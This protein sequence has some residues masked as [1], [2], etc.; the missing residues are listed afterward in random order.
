MVSDE[1]LVASK[2]G[3]ARGSLSHSIIS[4]LIPSYRWVVWSGGVLRHTA[5]AYYG[6]EVV[7]GEGRMEDRMLGF[8][9]LNPTY[10]L[11]GKN[12][13]GNRISIAV[14]IRALDPLRLAVRSVDLLRMRVAIRRR[15]LSHSLSTHLISYRGD[16]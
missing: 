14:A 2:G 11:S 3:G 6:G 16:N 9:V 8:A 4:R 13:R 12:G 1:W 15:S 7:S 10:G 5:Y